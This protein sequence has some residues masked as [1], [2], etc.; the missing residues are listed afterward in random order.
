MR[1]LLLAYLL[2]ICMIA[3]S[4]KQKTPEPYRD[5]IMDSLK[6]RIAHKADS[7][8][9][10]AADKI[11]SLYCRPRVI[12]GRIDIIPSA[13]TIYQGKPWKKGYIVIWLY[14]VTGTDTSF[15]KHRIKPLQ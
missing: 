11:D 3:S 9:M 15:Y 2:S 6:A 13:P 8:A 7:M 10:S 5:S 12:V 14:T 4:G 1:W